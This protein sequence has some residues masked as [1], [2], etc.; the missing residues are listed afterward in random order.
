MTFNG[1]S[2]FGV[3]KASY[4]KGLGLRRECFQGVPLHAKV[5]GVEQSICRWSPSLSMKNWLQFIF[6]L[7]QMVVATGCCQVIAAHSG[8]GGVCSRRK[9]V[10]SRATL[11]SEVFLQVWCEGRRKECWTARDFFPFKRT[12]CSRRRLGVLGGC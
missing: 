4:C 1:K 10:C 3:K 9:G 2:L 5:Q 12:C 8:S 11:A 6:P 7:V